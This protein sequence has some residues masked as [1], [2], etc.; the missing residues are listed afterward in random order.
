MTRGGLLPLAVLALSAACGP[1]P[2]GARFGVDTQA[3]QGMN[4]S[5]LVATPF[6][7]SDKSGKG[8]DCNALL[9]SYQDLSGFGPLAKAVTVEV[10]SADTSETVAFDDLP[11]GGME[12]LALG[13]DGAGGSGKIVADGCG[14]GTVT[15]GNKVIV[16]VGMQSVGP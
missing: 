3:L 1:A 14:A 9:A 7:G 6:G 15:A 2:G 11:L 16:V 8:I 13:Y 10:A 4:V 5:S 12:L